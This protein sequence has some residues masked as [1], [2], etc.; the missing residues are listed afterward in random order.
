MDQP[1]GKK[2][3][4][5]LSEKPVDSTP[6]D[7]PFFQITVL[8]VEILAVAFGAM[9]LGRFLNL[10]GCKPMGT[11]SGRLAYWPVEGFEVT[12][13]KFKGTTSKM[14]AADPTFESGIGQHL[15]GLSS[16]DVLPPAE[17]F[18]PRHPGGPLGAVKRFLGR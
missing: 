13:L 6:V 1:I 17:D 4:F 8:A 9:W 18:Y 16:S 15:A 3:G 10:P 14:R 2:F 7:L 12:L 11:A 5:P